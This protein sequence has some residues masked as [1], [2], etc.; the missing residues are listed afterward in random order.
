MAVKLLF[1]DNFFWFAAEYEAT[2]YI[3]SYRWRP[4]YMDAEGDPNS[5]RINLTY[6]GRIFQ[7]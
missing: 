1:K 2:A 5:G 3:F 4:V 7:W 6:L